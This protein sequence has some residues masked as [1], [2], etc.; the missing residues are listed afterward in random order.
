MSHTL[1]TSPTVGTYPTVRTSPTVPTSP[2]VRTS[3]TVRHLQCVPFLYFFSSTHPL[4][5]VPYITSPLARH[6]QYFTYCKERT[7]QHQQSVTFFMVFILW[8]KSGVTNLQIIFH[9]LFHVL[10]GPWSQDTGTPLLASV[11]L[12]SQ[13]RDLASVCTDS[14]TSPTALTYLSIWKM[15]SIYT[16]QLQCLQRAPNAVKPQATS[17]SHFLYF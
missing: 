5:Y 17:S 11:L 3:P 8:N 16:V 6:L 7:L 12:Q 15:L 1:R 2:L 10:R 13:I 14:P 9:A 4:Q